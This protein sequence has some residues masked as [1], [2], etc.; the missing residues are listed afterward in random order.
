MGNRESEQERLRRLRDK[1]IRARD[2][3]VKERKVGRQVAA[4]QRKKR[5][6]ESFIRDS[7]G[8]VSHKVRGA[9]LGALLGL[10]VMLLLP[11][12]MEGRM[13]DILGI[14]AFPFLIALGVLIGASFDWRDDI[15]DHIE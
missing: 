4:Q 14:V 8:A 9:F 1:Q 12:V 15:R 10:L 13:A 11:M 6:N 3:Q 5:K 2:P 7:A